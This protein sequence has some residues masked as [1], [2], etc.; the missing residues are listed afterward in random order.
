MEAAFFLSTSQETNVK[1]FDRLMSGDG[2]AWAQAMGSFMEKAD[3]AFGML[4]TELWSRDGLALLF[5]ALRKFGKKR[6][7]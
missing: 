6:F 1:E 7:A 2:A 4:G 5:K 3:I